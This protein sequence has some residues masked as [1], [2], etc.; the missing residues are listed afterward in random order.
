VASPTERVPLVCVVTPTF[1]RADYLERTM[2]SVLEQDYPRIEYHVMDG[3]STDGTVEILRRQSD[4]LASWTSAPDRGQAAAVRSGF[5]RCRGRILAYLNSDDVYVPGAVRR[6]VETFE[7]T[8]ADLVF[9][10]V[11]LVD[12]QGKRIRDLKFTDFDL[13]TFLYEGGNLNQ[14]GAFWTRELYDRVGGIDPAFRFGLDTDFF[15]RAAQVGRFVHHRGIVAEFRIH[16]GSKSSTIWGVGLAEWD[17]I[18]ARHID[19]A[20]PRW[21]LELLRRR[22]QLR[23]A[24]GYIRQGDAAYLLAGIVDRLVRRPRP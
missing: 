17:R 13:E 21:R 16:G 8:K 7:R 23:R 15:A 10:D 4:R 19:P 2:R 12:E 3:G 6:I 18:R 1:Q 22:S 9:G 5:E 11:R 14:A 20:T 24:I